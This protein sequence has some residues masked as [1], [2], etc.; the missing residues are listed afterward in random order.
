MCGAFTFLVP[1]TGIQQEYA[2]EADK[3]MKAL[4]HERKDAKKRGCLL[5]WS[6]RLKS[7]KSFFLLRNPE[8]VWDTSRCF[9]PDEVKHVCAKLDCNQ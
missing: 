6:L 2:L 5:Y 9:Y 3:V 7:L 8:P 4:V 1:R